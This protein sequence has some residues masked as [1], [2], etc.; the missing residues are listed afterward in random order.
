MLPNVIIELRHL[1]KEKYESFFLGT[2]GQ[3]ILKCEFTFNEE[4]AFFVRGIKYLEDDAQRP[5]EHVEP[6]FIKRMGKHFYDLITNKNDAFK[7][8]LSL[9]EE[10]KKGFYLILALDSKYFKEK[11]QVKE[12]DD[13][14]ALQKRLKSVLQ[15]RIKANPEGIEQISK[16][17]NLLWQIPWEYLYDGDEFLAL[18]SRI[19]ISR[20]PIGL[21][22]IST[23]KSPQPLRLLVVVS[24]PIEL[25]EL[26]S[27]ME[28]TII[29]EVL[30][31]ARRNGWLEID[32][33]ETATLSNLR[34]KIKHF[35]P[36]VL[37][38]TG[39]GGRLPITNE[40]FLAFE[41][42]D[43]KLKPL[44]GD[45]L[46]RITADCESLQLIVLSGC[47]TAQTHNQDAFRGIGTSL[48]QDN[49][50]AVL[51]MQYSILDKSGVE[52]ARK[53]YEELSRG[54]RVTEAVK[55]ARFRLYDLRGKDR[56]DW[57]IPI[58]YLRT[59]EVHLID[60]TLQSRRRVVEREQI[61]IGV[62]PVVRGFVGRKK[63]IRLICQAINNHQKTTVY[64]F[65]LGGIGKT[66]LVAKIIE[67]TQ[68]DKSIE[69]VCVIRCN[70]TD[71]IFANVIKKISNFISYQG[72]REHAKAAQYLTDSRISIDER[73]S[74]FNNITKDYKYL[75]I[76]DNF[77]SLFVGLSPNGELKDNNLTKFFS[78]LFNH[79]WKSTFIFTSRFEWQLLA[80]KS[81]NDFIFNFGVPLANLLEIQLSGL[82][83]H[84]IIQYMNNLE[85]SLSRLEYKEQLRLLPLIKGY[86]KI[87]E[88]LDSYLNVHTLSEVFKDKELWNK[89]IEDVGKFFIDGLWKELNNNE[90]K[91]LSFFSV[92]RRPLRKQDI[93]TLVPFLRLPNKLTRY[94][95]LEFVGKD[96]GYIVHPIV[97]EYVLSKFGKEKHKSLH[98]KAADFYIHRYDALLKRIFKDYDL[99]SL[100][101]L[102]AVMAILENQG[103]RKQVEKICGS[104]IE[105]HHHLF[106]AEEYKRA[107]YIVNTIFA[108][109]TTLGYRDHAKYLMEK[110]IGTLDTLNGREK[111]GIEGNYATLLLM[112]GKQ[113][114]ALT[115]YKKCVDYFKNT[116]DKRNTAVFISQQAEIYYEL[117]EYEKA[118][119][120]EQKALSLS[121]DV[122]DKQ[123]NAKS[124]FRIA[125]IHHRVGKCNEALISIRQAKKLAQELEN[126]QL[127]A[128]CLHLL[129][130]ILNSLGEYQKAFEYFS[131]SLNISKQT[132]DVANWTASLHEI[133]RFMLSARK[134][135]EALHCFQTE[136]EINREIGIPI[137]IAKALEAIG[138]VFER[139]GYYQEAMI[140]YREAYNLM[141]KFGSPI[142]VSNIERNIARAKE[143]IKK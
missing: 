92:F 140:K 41:G 100:R 21:K 12:S 13:S 49:L 141:K 42:D 76:F 62:L 46:K 33:L 4:D 125:Q 75:F 23:I 120:Y 57:G 104:L 94:S 133:G 66:A 24:S 71:P 102:C 108:F 132:G 63:E 35:Q 65:G 52:F 60:P 50:P 116:N 90:Q 85:G 129:G 109:L 27:E 136:L 8:Y 128:G 47:M 9:N 124:Y 20:K 32:F 14:D 73:V 103:G 19:Y 127:E 3:E 67:K 81:K 97:S 139:Q 54:S 91:T 77:E 89:V 142:D 113:Q 106:Q 93:H 84:Q 58:L 130:C 37:H 96:Q 69:G 101:K 119:N 112:E 61:N 74:L 10:L 6:G 111:I 134:I 138:V 95:L 78:S 18:S 28:I 59:P 7:N 5:N 44:F 117:G 121:Q 87:V 82:D 123:G 70:E 29:Q 122:G 1:S 2:R 118:L 34:S 80:G 40:T 15:E 110:T 115:I 64:I 55:E 39:H 43:W 107:G 137:K 126:K 88:L 30:D 143:K 114:E 38:Y 131:E 22:E 48:L 135:K 83:N 53:F 45:D 79:R 26:N 99:D 51:A 31:T 25:Q 105:I 86:P 98:K 17:A 56:A 72:K 68:Q 16:S 11:L 36:H